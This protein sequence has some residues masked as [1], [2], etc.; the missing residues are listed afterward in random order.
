MEFFAS[1]PRVPG[2][3]SDSDRLAQGEVFLLSRQR[4]AV[5]DFDD[6]SFDLIPPMD[7]GIITATVTEEGRGTSEISTGIAFVPNDFDGDGQSDAEENLNGGDSNGDGI[8]DAAQRNVTSFPATEFNGQPV[9]GIGI[10]VGSLKPDTVPG[11]NSPTLTPLDELEIPV[12]EKFTQLFPAAIGFNVTVDTPGDSV[13]VSLSGIDLSQINCLLMLKRKTAD[14]EREWF[15]YND[16]VDVQF[17]AIENTITYTLTD[18]TVG[19]AD[20][21]PNGLIVDP[22]IPAFDP[23]RP[24]IEPS[25]DSDGDG[26]PDS[27]E[28]TF[29][30]SPTAANPINDTDRDGVTDFREFV[31]GTDPTDASN[32]LKITITHSDGTT[33]VTVP[34]IL[35]R[36][37]QLQTS[38]DLKAFSNIGDPTVGT[39][40]NVMLIHQN[41]NDTTTKFYRVLISVP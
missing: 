33:A 2:R 24:P 23:N 40:E 11:L 37:Y 10:A 25:G 21:S 9:G 41:R 5:R 15:C 27:F 32:R 18:G 22:V 6:H 7:R 4:T 28:Q 38:I 26:L 16:F 19:D 36:T 3:L 20:L 31:H 17:N 35:E 30:G 1:P 34:S 14:G 29:F 8:P 13:D 12:P 39:G